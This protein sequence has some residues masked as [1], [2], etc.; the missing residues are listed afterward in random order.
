MFGDVY[1]QHPRFHALRYMATLRAAR[2]FGLGMEAANAIALRFDPRQCDD[3]R[4]ADALAAALLDS[5]AV[6]VPGSPG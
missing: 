4:L 5:G 2:D 6:E 1:P 3:G